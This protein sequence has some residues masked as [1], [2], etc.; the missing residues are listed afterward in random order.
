MYYISAAY[1]DND[2]FGDL[3]A[4]LRGKIARY[5]TRSC[6]ANSELGQVHEH[7]NVRKLPI[8]S[9]DQP[10]QPLSGHMMRNV[11]SA[12][13]VCITMLASVKAILLRA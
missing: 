12:D 7:F 6:I 1:H 8:W 4:A 10:L 3:P 2:F 9:H 5:R 13:H 11:S